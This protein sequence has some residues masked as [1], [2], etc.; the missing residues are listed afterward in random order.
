MGINR[1]FKR[2][3][4]ES[5]MGARKAEGAELRNVIANDRLI[6]LTVKKNYPHGTSCKGKI[7]RLT[8]Q[9]S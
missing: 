8:C 9:N 3:L 1:I 4:S 5:V 6:G 2:N 7:R